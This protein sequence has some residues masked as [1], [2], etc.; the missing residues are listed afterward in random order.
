MKLKHR[1]TL[2]VTDDEADRYA[3][4]LLTPG[5]DRRQRFWKHLGQLVMLLGAVS[6]PASLHP[7]TAAWRS[8]R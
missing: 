5:R 2:D 4:R 3:G 7:H 1:M 6:G 8:R